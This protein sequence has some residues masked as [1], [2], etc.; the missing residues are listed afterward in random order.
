MGG[1]SFG[2]VPMKRSRSVVRS[3]V[4]SNA[5]FAAVTNTRQARPRPRPKSKAGTG[6]LSSHHGSSLACTGAALAE[7]VVLWLSIVATTVMFF[8]C[9]KLAGWMLVPYLAWVSFAMVLNFAIW[10]MNAS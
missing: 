3:R 5:H 10:R 6:R 9:R 8:R 7:I 2:E 1:M 4:V